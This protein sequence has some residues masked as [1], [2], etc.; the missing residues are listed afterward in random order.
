MFRAIFE[1]LPLKPYMPSQ[2]APVTLL[3]QF[4]QLTNSLSV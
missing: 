1:K 4:K 3:I 2:V